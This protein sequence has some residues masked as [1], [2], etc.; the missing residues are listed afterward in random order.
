MELRKV[1][2]KFSSDLQK[3]I[4]PNLKY[5][6]DIFEEFLK[7]TLKEDSKWLDLGCGH[8]I[9]PVWRFSNEKKI[10]KI[11]KQI[12]GFDYNF[13]SLKK[14]KT[15]INKVRGDISY[16]PFKDDT[17]DVVTSNMVLEHLKEPI[18]QFREIYRIL[19]PGGEF[20]F[21]TPNAYGYTTLIGQIVPD[22][23]K[24]KLVYFLQMR[25]EEDI[26]PTYYRINSVKNIKTVSQQCGFRIKRIKLIASTPQFSML[27]I[28]LFFEMLWLKLTMK[29]KLKMFRTNIIAH[30]I[31]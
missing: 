6:Q 5:S 27:P 17:F 12:V 18:I 23:L 24:N 14:H 21:H 25:K 7:N 28:L 15:I 2:N 10:V 4:I 31:K 3:I 11:P 8:Q 13:S 19:K 16:L 29:K 9:L 20:I 26:F 22:I 30:I 1:L